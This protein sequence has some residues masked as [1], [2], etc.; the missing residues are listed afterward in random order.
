MT[1]AAIKPANDIAPK[2][3]EK[4]RPHNVYESIEAMTAILAKEGI[5]KAQGGSGEIKYKFRGIDDI[6]NAIAPYMKECALN[7]VPKVTGREEKE[8]A[9][10]NGGFSLWVILHLEFDLINTLDASKVTIPWIAEAV[11]YSDKATQKAISQGYKTVC[12]NTFNIPTE[13]EEDT[14]GEK[15]EFMGKRAGAFESEEL[16]KA[17]ITN[18]KDAFERADSLPKLKEIETFYHDKLII[19]GNSEDTL[20]KSAASDIRQL[21]TAKYNTFTAAPKGKL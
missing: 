8:R 1:N 5:T 12:I 6:R 20:D 9:T 4:R 19:M 7:I 11:D 13:G 3:E 18:C 16:R 15:K 21:Y 14:D 17:W 10:K 2:A